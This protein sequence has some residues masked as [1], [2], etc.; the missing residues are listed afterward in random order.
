MLG[1][2]IILII[3]F[4]IAGFLFSPIVFYVDTEENRYEIRQIP[5]FTFFLSMR[6]QRFIPGIKLIG[7]N[8]PLSK[9]EHKKIKK[10]DTAK[11]RRKSFMHKSLSTWRYTLTQVAK[12]FVV[13][14]I[15]VDVDTD[16][17]VMNAQLVPLFI[18]L[19]SE[20]ASFTTNYTGRAYVHFEA[21]NRPAR[22]LWILIRFFTKK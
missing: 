11:P 8:V 9:A 6:D 10:G 12:S 13:Q 3:V 4:L 14:K 7:I 2:I 19:S 16:D 15:I 5:V 1:L 17:V 20:R 22:L 18:L 21:E